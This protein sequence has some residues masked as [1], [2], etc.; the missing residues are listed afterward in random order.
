MKSYNYKSLFLMALAIAILTAMPVLAQTVAITG[1]KVYPVSGPPIEGGTV[2]IVN[3]RITAV[4]SG[5]LVSLKLLFP[6]L[7]FDLRASNP[8]IAP[9]CVSRTAPKSGAIATSPTSKTATPISWTASP[10][11]R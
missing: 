5:I 4:G 2:I 6:D 11:S 10:S 7:E 3:G 8:R 1:G 9:S